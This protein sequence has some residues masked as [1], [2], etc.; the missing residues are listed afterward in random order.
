MTESL[1]LSSFK[2]KRTVWQDPFYFIAFG[3]GSGLM[4]F[5]PGTFGTL[6][7][8]PI[9]LLMKGLSPFWY[10]TW[11]VLLFLFVFLYA[12]KCQMNLKCMII[13]ALYLMKSLVFY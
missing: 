9:Y 7:A 6:A 8:I 1:S 4:P 11:V 10:L 12:K 3:F 5:M 2:L 13:A